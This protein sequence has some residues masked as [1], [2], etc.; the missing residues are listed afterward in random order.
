MEQYKYIKIEL[1][2]GIRLKTQQKSL[3]RL[4][5]KAGYKVIDINDKLPKDLIENQNLAMYASIE[6]Y[7]TNHELY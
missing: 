4:L 1:I 3:V 6:T 7:N 2:R 5:S